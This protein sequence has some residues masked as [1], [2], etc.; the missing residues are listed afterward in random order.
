MDALSLMLIALILWSAF[1][2]SQAKRAM[3]GG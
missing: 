1:K 3:H 2:A